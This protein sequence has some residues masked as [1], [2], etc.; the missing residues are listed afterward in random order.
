VECEAVGQKL[1]TTQEAGDPET[2]N[3]MACFSVYYHGDSLF[4]PTVSSGTIRIL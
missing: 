1:S 3:P 2:Y 4:L